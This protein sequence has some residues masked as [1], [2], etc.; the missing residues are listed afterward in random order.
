VSTAS[1]PASAANLGPGYDVLALALDVRCRV[2]AARADEWTVTTGGV[3]V[4]DGALTM[5]R[6]TAEAV[7]AGGAFSVAVESDIPIGRGLGSS[8]A[9]IVAAAGAIG[10]AVEASTNPVDLL[11]ACAEVEGHPDNVA[12]ALYGGL[13]A[14][15]A[16]GAV[17]KLA[18]HPSLLVLVA[19]PEETLS[20]GEARRATAA[21]VE[22]RVAARTAARLAFL[23]EGLR[24]ADGGALIEAAGDELHELRRAHL[25]PIT[26][27]LIE[28]AREADA[29]H[30]A[31]SGAGPSCVAFV[32]EETAD[33]VEAAMG[34]V[35]DGAGKVFDL[36]IDR[37]GLSVG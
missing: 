6:R 10:A 18:L 14:V 34:T 13:V 19:V 23:I 20:T 12:A 16:R 9:L 17:W 5:V 21:P 27:R 24:S 37:R 2:T 11:E 31:W 25:S 30:A 1:A 22:T 32:T 8:A 28:A 15:S 3:P 7:G 33:A 26:G 36:A 35:L 4:D 29:L